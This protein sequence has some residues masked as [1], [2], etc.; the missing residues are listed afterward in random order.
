[1]HQ[2]MKEKWNSKITNGDTVYI[3]GDIAMRGTNEELIALVAQLKG[4]KVL[5]KGNH[6]DVSD[7]RYKNIFEEIYDYKEITDYVNQDAY[8]LVLSLYPILTQAEYG[9]AYAV[10]EVL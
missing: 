9:N 1:M 2:Y 5:I 3:L 10:R 4:R 8:K 6:D 7:M